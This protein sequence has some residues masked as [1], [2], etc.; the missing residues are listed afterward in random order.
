MST[1]PQPET[2]TG[3][4]SSADRCWS[5][6]VNARRSLHAALALGDNNAERSARTRVHAAKEQYLAALHREQA[7]HDRAVAAERST[8]R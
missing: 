7:A 1:T 8:L 2:L 5:A 4:M 3:T 6:L